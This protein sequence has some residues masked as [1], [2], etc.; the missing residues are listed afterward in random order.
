MEIRPDLSICLLPAQDGADL[1]PCLAAL[2]ACSDPLSLE[3]FLP[4]GA[5]CGD[6]HASPHLHF[7]DLPLNAANFFVKE[8]WQRARGRYLGLWHGGVMASPASLFSLVEF[9]DAHPDVAV[10]G[11]RF[12]NEA[13]DVL[14][15]AFQRTMLIPDSV[16]PGWDGLA[17]MEVDWLSSA[18]LVV[19]RLALEDIRLPCSGLGGIW[20]RRLCQRFQQ[21]GWHIFFVHLARVVS[22]ERF[23]EPSTLWQRFMDD[24]LQV[25][26][27][28]FG[29]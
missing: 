6:Y 20:E 4:Q 26:S 11:P 8:V 21:Q 9:L 2:F 29:R 15:T 17:T 16:M 10:A 24:W 7:L 23:C 3:V 18:A 27:D 28:P 14:A 1:S 13:G 22:R 25:V 12:F 5:R 19:N